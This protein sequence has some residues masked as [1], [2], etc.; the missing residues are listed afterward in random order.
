MY[1]FIRCAQKHTSGANPT[2]LKHLE[3]N[4]HFSAEELEFNYL[5]GAP[6]YEFD[7]PSTL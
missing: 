1:L 3:A 6:L 5:L 4:H 2:Y 7:L